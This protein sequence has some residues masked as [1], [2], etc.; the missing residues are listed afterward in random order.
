MSVYK[1]YKGRRLKPG[2]KEWD[3]GKWWMEFRL[4]GHDIH[5]SIPGARTK[6]QAERAESN[7]RESIYDGKYNKAT[8]TR[9][10]SEFVDEVYLPWAKANKASWEN[11]DSRAKVLK[12]FF[13]NRPIRDITPMLIRRLKGELM[14]GVTRSGTP[15]RGST[16]NRYRSLLSKIMEMA[17]EEGL[18]DVNPVR[19]VPKE[20]EGA[21]R[22]RYL[23][24]EEEERLLPTFTGKLAHLYSPV[25]INID[26]GLRVYSE[27]LMLEVQHVNLSSE[28]RFFQVGG[29]DIELR[30]GHL[31]VAKSKNGKPRTVP[32]TAR[33]RAE[34]VKLIQDRT[35]GFVFASHRTGVNFTSLRD[36]FMKACE[37]A[38][39]PYGLHTPN[40]I[41]LHSLRHT[42]ATRL[43]DKN[44]HPYTIMALMGHSSAKMSAVYSH[45]SPDTV[46][47]AIGRLE[48]R[49]EVLEFALR[50]KSANAGGD[51]LAVADAIPAS[52]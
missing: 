2:D 47:A 17:F 44:I 8:K 19:R 38:G 33:A 22:E 35:E 40:G 18:I 45:A 25:V 15:R 26:T 7:V 4:R 39:I 50:Q 36:G 31:L 23:T 14:A 1:R 13:G 32:L 3:K 28:S 49:G 16:F 24:H 41:T 51:G 21:G 9:R 29:R 11:D 5:E 48:A 12:E 27:L 46:E 52:G 10:F 34:L 6:A 30:P 43:Q 42:F 37:L 20:A